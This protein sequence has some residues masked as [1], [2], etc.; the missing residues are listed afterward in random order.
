MNCLVPERAIVPRLLTRS[1]DYMLA[2]CS[3]KIFFSLS[4]RTYSLG[5]TNTG[6]TDGK[7][8]LLLVGDDVDAQVLARVELAWVGQGLVA[9]LVQGIG[10]VGNK[11]SEEDLLVGVDGVDD[12][13]EKL[14]D[15]SLELESLRHCGGYQREIVTSERRNVSLQFG[16]GGCSLRS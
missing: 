15:L 5:H 9:D 8:L 16:F 4:G 6:V 11:F 10:G 12:E 1:Y 7:G 2:L 3:S 13:G 14:R